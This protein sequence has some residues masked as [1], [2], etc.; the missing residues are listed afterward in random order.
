MNNQPSFQF[1]ASE[2]FPHLAAAPIVEAVIHWQ[3]RAARWQGEEELREQL[4]E[5]LPGFPECHPQQLIE[6]HPEMAGEGS[7]PWIRRDKWHGF[8][9]VSQDKLSI[10]QFTRDGIAVSRLTPYQSWDVFSADAWGLWRIFAD[11]TQPSEVQ[12]LGVRFIN[13]I[14]L[15][16]REEVQDILTSPPECLEDIGLPTVGFLYQSRHSVPD[17]P[18]E[19]NVVRTIQPP[20]PDKPNEFG[21]ILDIDAGTTQPFACDNATLKEKLETMH[22]LKNKVF[23]SLLSQAT[24]LRLQKVEP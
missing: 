17:T 11:M 13:R 21:L 24:I 20:A 2:S 14:V 4:S 9:L 6:L 15:R 16:R 3:A 12:R 5:L 23:F 10:V 7:E 8:R 19:I 18:M 22:W 1:D